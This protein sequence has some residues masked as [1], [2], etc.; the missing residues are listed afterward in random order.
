MLYPE[1]LPSRDIYKPEVITAQGINGNQLF[2]RKSKPSG[3]TLE[4]IDVDYKRHDIFEELFLA[5][6]NGVQFLLTDTRVNKTITSIIT[7]DDIVRGTEDA[8]GNID[9]VSLV[10]SI[11]EVLQL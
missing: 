1:T 11:K 5:S 2:S 6:Q 7:V 3:F 10:I 8:F 4:E 9:T